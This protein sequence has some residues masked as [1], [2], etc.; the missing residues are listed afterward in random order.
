MA[1]LRPLK[2]RI[3]TVI[4]D[5]YVWLPDSESPRASPASD[6]VGDWPISIPPKCRPG[7][8]AYVYRELLGWVPVVGV[9][10]SPFHGDCGAVKVFR[11][12]SKMPLFVTA[13]GMDVQEAADNVRRM[14]GRHRIPTLLKR[15]DQ[16]AR[17][18]A[19]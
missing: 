5:S 8:G 4:V 3:S 19:S 2:D 17:R 6:P 15:V 11:G 18:E 12:Q 7:M 9:A 13:A 14:H 1:V 16:L 10:K